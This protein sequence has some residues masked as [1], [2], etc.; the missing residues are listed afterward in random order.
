MKIVAAIVLKDS[1]GRANIPG[2]RTEVRRMGALGRRG[3]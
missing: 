1:G 2:G 3:D